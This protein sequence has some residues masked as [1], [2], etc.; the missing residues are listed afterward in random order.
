MV[1]VLQFE[2]AT[3]TTVVQV[4]WETSRLATFD[5]GIVVMNG[6][7][8]TLAAFDYEGAALWRSKPR[9]GKGHGIL[10][11][12]TATSGWVAVVTGSEAT[13]A[14][15]LHLFDPSGVEVW[16]HPL[17]EWEPEQGTGLAVSVAVAAD[18]KVG[19]AWL[20]AEGCRVSCLDADKTEAYT[21]T[22]PT[23][24]IEEQVLRENN[25]QVPW[26]HEWGSPL[27]CFFN[28]GK[29]LAAGCRGG[30]R[31]SSAGCGNLLDLLA[32]RREAGRVWP[33]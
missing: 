24:D 22:I 20:T 31:C 13:S 15:V 5:E 27:V 33:G 14:A 6:A 17:T 28:H 23:G 8:E 26:W 11:W 18:G 12:A 32:G 25:G 29:S 19:V 30:G 3:D 7:E 4:D 2:D 21:Y 16:R 1:H 10:A 9:S